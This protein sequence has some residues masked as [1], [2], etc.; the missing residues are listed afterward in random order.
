MVRYHG[1]SVAVASRLGLEMTQ[2]QAPDHHWKDVQVVERALLLWIEQH[3]TPGTMPTDAQLYVSGRG[4][5]AQGIKRHHRGFKAVTAAL[6]L[7]PGSNPPSVKP[8]AYWLKWENVLTEMPAVS[9]ACGVAGQMSTQHQ[10]KANGYTSLYSALA[11]HYGGLYKFAERIDLPMQHTNAPA[12]HFRDIQTLQAA[13]MEFVAEHGTA[14]TMPTFAQLDI[15]GR[16]DLTDA[17]KLYHG[18]SK[19][20]AGKTSLENGFF[21]ASLKLARSR[22]AR[23][24]REWNSDGSAR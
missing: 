11:K 12:N 21:G 1:G 13:V 2:E 7:R 20:V 23:L 14:N 4:D 9:K 15:R 3:G 5:L 10:L 6:G 8:G 18:G 17:M 19:A 16:S 24:W 22:V